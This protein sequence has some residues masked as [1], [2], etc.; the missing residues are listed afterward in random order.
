[1]TALPL[2]V[3]DNFLLNYHIGHALV[4]V[5]ALVMLASLPLR[6]RKVLALNT[7]LFGVIFMVTPYQMVES[8]LFRLGGLGLVIVAPLL[9]VT[10]D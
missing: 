4:V 2:Q 5:F 7:L 1:M 9:Y 8:I 6:S 10:A 3:I